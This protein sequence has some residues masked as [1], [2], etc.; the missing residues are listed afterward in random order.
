MTDTDDS[1]AAPK[2]MIHVIDPERDKTFQALAATSGYLKEQSRNKI[3]IQCTQCETKMEKPR[4]CSKCRS[5]LYCSQ[6]CQKKNWPIHKRICHQVEQSSGVLKLVRMFSVNP[7]IM[8][9]LKTAIVLDC[10]LLGNPRIGFDVPFV[11]QVDIG[12]EPSDI[13]DFVGLYFDDK[14]IRDKLQGMVQ[15][16]SI[17]PWYPGMKGAQ[18]LTPQRLKQWREARAKHD[19]EGYAKDPVGLLDFSSAVLSRNTTSLTYAISLGCHI[20]PVILEMA[21][22]REPF[23]R[24]CPLAGTRFK[25]PMS[26]MT[27]LEYINIH[28]RA[29][30]QNQLRLRSEMTEQDK[31][32][33]RAAGRGEDQLPARVLKEKM[34]REIMYL[35]IVGQG[36]GARSSE[37]Q[38]GKQRR[39]RRSPCSF[40]G[41]WGCKGLA[42]P[43][44]QPNVRLC[45]IDHEKE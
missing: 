2:A 17:T 12:L 25:Q 19:A 35:N 33:I 37:T 11:A 26:P 23:V 32:V 41:T 39:P 3:L 24:V 16:N 42:A 8:M 28:I 29:D 20:S 7:L 13:F 10:N 45:I 38:R 44:A 21:M 14:A 27:C 40:C 22:E 34:E 1:S 4:K 6:E 18:P 30:T 31:E 43:I 9:Y 36:Q 5:V 15:V